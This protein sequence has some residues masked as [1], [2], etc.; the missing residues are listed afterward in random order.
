MKRLCLYLFNLFVE[1]TLINNIEQGINFYA[2]EHSSNG[3]SVLREQYMIGN[4]REILNNTRGRKIFATMGGFH[5]SLDGGSSIGFTMAS[6]L[7]NEIRIASIV[8]RQQADTSRW[9]YIIRINENLKTTPFNSTYTGNWP[10][11]TGW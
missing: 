9:Q 3:L 6:V 7:K 10:W 8:L 2:T 5:A 1:L 4:F 11:S